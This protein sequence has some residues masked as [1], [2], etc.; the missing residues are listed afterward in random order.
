RARRRRPRRGR[1]GPGGH[2]DP[3]GRRTGRRRARLLRRPNLP[4]G[5]HPA[6]RAGGHRQEPH[7]FGPPPLADGP[8]RRRDRCAMSASFTHHDIQELLGAYALDAVDDDER[9]VIEA[10]LAD[11]PRC[12]AEVA[13][14]REVAAFLGHTGGSAP[15]GVWDRITA[16]LEEAPPPL[17]LAPPAPIAPRR[18]VPWARWAVAAASV[19][20]IVAVV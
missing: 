12:R 8:R 14:D 5:G 11:C 15:T 3:P 9:G 18:R 7:P 1:R 4:R 10:H 19:A 16:S 13:D 6:R 20:A 2:V 17:A